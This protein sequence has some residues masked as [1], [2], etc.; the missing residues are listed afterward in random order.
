MFTSLQVVVRHHAHI[1]NIHLIT[2]S[3]GNKYLVSCSARNAVML[4]GDCVLWYSTQWTLLL[5]FPP[6]VQAYPDGAIAY[7][8]SGKDAGASQ[9]R[10]HLQILPQK[11]D[12]NRTAPLPLRDLAVNAAEQSGVSPLQPFELR[13]LPFQCYATLLPQRWDSSSF[14]YMAKRLTQGLLTR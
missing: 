13:E 10:K 8:N 1:A 14:Q 9:P 5:M 7:F 6:A 12:G 2:C 4:V 3:P 11:L